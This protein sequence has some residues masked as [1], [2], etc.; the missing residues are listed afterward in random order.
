MQG[1]SILQRSQQY[2]QPMVV[3]EGTDMVM[4]ALNATN[5]KRY[6][7]R[8]QYEPEHIWWE[9]RK[10][11]A[12]LVLPP[13]FLCAAGFSSPVAGVAVSSVATWN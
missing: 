7:K 13:V 6:H 12:A 3:T 11:L 10:C 9:M 4:V 2:C 5:Y 8:A 1:A